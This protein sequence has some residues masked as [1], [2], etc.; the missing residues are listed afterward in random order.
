MNPEKGTSCMSSSR[1]GFSV[2]GGA[3]S[4][5]NDAQLLDKEVVGAFG[6]D[7]VG[8]YGSEVLV[9]GHFGLKRA[10]PGESHRDTHWP[11]P[12]RS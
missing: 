5:F 2:R 8:G 6:S 12:H 4:F 11:A 7:S 10:S 9:L 1:V 3:A